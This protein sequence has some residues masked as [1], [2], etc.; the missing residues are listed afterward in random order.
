MSNVRLVAQNGPVP[1][2]NPSWA[3]AN[4]RWAVAEEIADAA[5]RRYP[6]DIRAIG[7]HGALAHGDDAD[8]SAVHLVVV[9]RRPDVGPQ[10]TGRRV[11]NV[12]VDC[13]VISADEYL[14]HA[15]TLSTSWPLA[16]DQY[17]TTRPI[18]DPTG[19]HELLCDTH[20]ARLAGADEREFAALARE[21]WC[22][23]ATTLARAGALAARYDSDGALLTLGAARLAVALVD[24]LLNRTY[25][26]GSA[27]AVR[28]CRLGDAGLD[29]LAARL[30]TQAEELAARG[31]PVDAEP[32][33]L[34]A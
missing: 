1:S 28:R 8:G 10:P 29:E 9:T 2:S 14:A 6:D 31:V 3:V 11:A 24:G 30:R 23:A 15:R 27:D 18:Y 17:V 19:W 4:P 20:L 26:R 16:A 21:A 25:F 33:D 7:V 5:L 34:F 22:P 13:G 32:P 12:I